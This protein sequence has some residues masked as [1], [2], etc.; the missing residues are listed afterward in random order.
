MKTLASIFFALM[1]SACATSNV[2][3]SIRA[4]ELKQGTGLIILSLTNKDAVYLG[5]L[6]QMAPTLR[7]VQEQTKDVI[8][9]E[10]IKGTVF[11]KHIE[12]DN[13]WTIGRVAA[14]ELPVGTYRL[15]GLSVPSIP[16]HP[17]GDS[18][19]V[20]NVSFLVKEKETTYVG[21]INVVFISDKDNFRTAHY[22]LTVNDELLRDIEHVKIKWPNLDLSVIKKDIAKK[23]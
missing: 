13:G 1:L 10:G 18:I 2:S 9:I 21:N 11:E 16:Y 20:P 8:A 3:S 14:V 12:N 4:T 7:F 15:Q 6:N 22:V 17:S 19:D 23:E 5:G